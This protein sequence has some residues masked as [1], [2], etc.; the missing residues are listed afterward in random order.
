MRPIALMLAA[1]GWKLHY[2]PVKNG[3]YSGTSF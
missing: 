3:L 2:T 1:T